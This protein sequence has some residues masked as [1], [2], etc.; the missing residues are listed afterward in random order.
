MDP[1]AMGTGDVKGYSLAHDG[2]GQGDGLQS[3]IGASDIP[4]PGYGSGRKE[5]RSMIT[6][7]LFSMT[8]INHCDNSYPDSTNFNIILMSKLTGC[9][10]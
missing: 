10:N 9:Y 5:K 4:R 8:G 2:I 1:A 6:E 3:D 7:Q